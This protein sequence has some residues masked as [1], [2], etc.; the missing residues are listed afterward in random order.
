MDSVP[1]QRRCFIWRRLLARFLTMSLACRARQ[2]CA[3]VILTS[4]MLNKLAGM[5][6][7]R[8]IGHAAAAFADQATSPL[9]MAAREDCQCLC[10]SS[11]GTGSW[12]AGR[13][14][15]NLMQAQLLLQG[16]GRT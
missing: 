6:L 8:D 11:S 4:R 10:E 12:L 15:S 5:P 16:Q 9:Q 2:P 1:L 14:N 3:S 7:S 13:H